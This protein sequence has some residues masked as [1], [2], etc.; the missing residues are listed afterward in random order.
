[1]EVDG[2]MALAARVV[3]MFGGVTPAVPKLVID[4]EAPASL[5]K[6][7]PPVPKLAPEPSSLDALVESVE[8][9][10]PDFASTAASD[11][12]VTLLFSDVEDFSAMTVRLG[13]RRAHE[14]IRDH[15][16]IVRSELKAH[17][18]DE[19]ELMGDGF[20]LAFK[21]AR[22]ALDCAVALQKRFAEYNESHVDEPLGVRMSL[23]TGEAIRDAHK[24]FGRT[25]IV[26]AR[27]TGHAHGGEILVSSL[28]RD[29][30][31]S[32]CALPFG[33]VREVEL[34][35]LSG[36]HGICAL[37]W[38]GREPAAVAESRP[39]VAP[40]APARP[41]ENAFRRTGDFWTLDFDGA[42]ITMRDTKGLNYLAR[43]LAEPHREI[44]AFELIGGG[45]SA[46][47]SARQ[48][49]PARADLGHAGELLDPK[50]RAE[51]RARLEELQSELDEAD[52]AND[53]GRASRLREEM[54][55]LSQELSAAFGL[56]GRA[57]KAA[58]S[59]ERARKAVA[60]RVNQSLARIRKE[61]PALGAHLSN[62]VRLGTFCEYRPERPMTW[63]L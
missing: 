1:V 44:H 21:S 47:V 22:R 32:D 26:A 63:K 14:V 49:D 58:D 24:F 57:R 53:V 15:N 60:S 31:R 6:R 51:Y 3:E 10:R 37:G 4:A 52:G 54:E 23:H 38:D 19:V 27:I 43:L 36:L 61:H 12:T 11:G 42:A 7:P 35:G 41:S 46:G 28:F 50:A 39:P 16:A 29:L 45:Q 18:G 33:P 55:F 2:D 62:A 48:S 5:P 25:V 59:A 40:A 34:K 13:D 20:L 9:S 30:T 17:G 8:V 56:G